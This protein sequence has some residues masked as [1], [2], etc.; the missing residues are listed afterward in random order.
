VSS[1]TQPEALWEEVYF[2]CPMLEIP[3]GTL[4]PPGETPT[5]GSDAEHPPLGREE[6]EEVQLRALRDRVD[7]A[8]GWC[9]FHGPAA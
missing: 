2:L 1:L 3:V 5:D 9:V 6:G 4:L 7:A 8:I